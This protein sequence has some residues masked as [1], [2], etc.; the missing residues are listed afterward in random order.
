VRA[1]V[2]SPQFPQVSR[3]IERT[4]GPIRLRGG[5]TIDFTDLARRAGQQHI[6]VPALGGTTFSERLHRAIGASDNRAARARQGEIGIGFIN[7][8]A[9]KLGLYD[10]KSKLGLRVVGEYRPTRYR[11]FRRLAATCGRG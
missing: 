8:V 9:T 5:Y 7:A 6:G 3:I 2:V 10:V 4:G 1:L 11:Q